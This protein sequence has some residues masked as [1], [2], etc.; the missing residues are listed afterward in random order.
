MHTNGNGRN[1]DGRRFSNPYNYDPIWRPDDPPVRE[2]AG[3]LTQMDDLTTRHMLYQLL[4][5]IKR[6]RSNFWR[7]EDAVRDLFEAVFYQRRDL[8][9]L[10]E[11]VTA[12][13]S[14]VEHLIQK[15][16]EREAVEA[17]AMLEDGAELEAAL[18]RMRQP[19]TEQPEGGGA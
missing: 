16:A 9:M 7:V 15:E 1:G 18:D 2:T 8:H 10:E 17:L 13:R 4:G 19:V 5:F 11:E 3:F 6:L 12:L 14:Q